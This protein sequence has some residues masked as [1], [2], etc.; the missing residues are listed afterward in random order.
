MTKTQIKHQE[1]HEVYDKISRDYSQVV[2][3]EFPVGT[4]VWWEPHFGKGYIQGRV[5]G[6]DTFDSIRPQVTIENVKTRATHHVEA[7]S[8]RFEKPSPKETLK[9]TDRDV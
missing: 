1:I 5:I 6:M 3:E 7:V 9:L 4:L 2:R 8:L